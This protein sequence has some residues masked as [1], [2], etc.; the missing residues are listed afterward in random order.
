M[1]SHFQLETNTLLLGYILGQ[2]LNQLILNI[3]HTHTLTHSHI[4]TNSLLKTKGKS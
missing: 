4:K 1:E 2:P 3:I